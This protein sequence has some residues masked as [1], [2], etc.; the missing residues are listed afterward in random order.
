MD[1]SQ[2][3]TYFA[4]VDAAGN[5]VEAEHRIAAEALAG[6]PALAWTGDGYTLVTA[7]GGAHFARLDSAGEPLGHATELSDVWSFHSPASGV[8]F[9]GQSLAF[10]WRNTDDSLVSSLLACLEPSASLIAEGSL[11]SGVR[12]SIDANVVWTGERFGV[13][14]ADDRS[15]SYEIYFAEFD[16]RCQPRAAVVRISDTDGEASHP[17]LAWSGEFYGLSWLELYAEN[18]TRVRFQRITPAG[19]PL[20]E[21]LAWSGR[22]L[23]LAWTGFDFALVYQTRLK[24]PSSLYLSRVD[25]A[26]LRTKDQLVAA[27]WKGY[28]W[29]AAAWNQGRLAIVST[30]N[31]IVFRLAECP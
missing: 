7:A 25:S 13:T 27:D 29:T 1:Y 4:A 20:G 9:S 22:Q 6:S 10:V 12:A 18:D 28:V 30:Q 31:E 21:A 11:A 2:S 5:I 23:G 24:S 8:A 19:E 15:G 17:S 14:W 26:G 16:A 3:G